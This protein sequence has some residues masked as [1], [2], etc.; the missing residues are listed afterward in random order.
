[1]LHQ[2]AV[3]APRGDVFSALTTPAGLA[4]WWTADVEAKP[5]EGSAA[6]FG[7]GDRSTVFV[8]RIEEL[9]EAE[10]VRWTCTGRTDEW[11]GTELTWELLG[12][13]NATDVVFTHGNW[14]ATGDVYR[15]C[16]TTWGAL[17]YRLKAYAE[18]GDPDPLFTGRTD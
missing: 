2:I 6:L 8:M 5:K 16:N 11:E 3:G 9:I 7:F 4:G 13:D 14:D 18:T 12:D 17:L 1:M 15:I 10:L